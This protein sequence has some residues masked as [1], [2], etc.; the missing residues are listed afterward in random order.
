MT[1]SADDRAAQASLRARQ[2][3]GARYDA[4]AAPH[5][6]LLLARRGTA[7]F[8]RKL[9]DLT[10]EDLDDPVALA[11]FTR[12]MIVAQIGYQARALAHLVA[13]SRMGGPVPQDASPDATE[14]EIASGASLPCRALRSLFTHSA[15]HLS[16]EW[17]DIDD[18]GWSANIGLPD[19]R[20]V[21][22]CDTPRLRAELIWRRALDLTPGAGLADVP[23]E[24]RN[25]L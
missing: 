11:G 25:K 8:A 10:D 22:L 2:G 4:T 5:D 9:N 16:V 20:R 19:G 23:V 6:E 21:A 15:A 18:D 17:R 7:Y 3:P 12:R 14:A 1:Q 24:L 13:A